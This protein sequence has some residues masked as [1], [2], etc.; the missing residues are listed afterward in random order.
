MTT[1]IEGLPRDARGEPVFRAPWQAQAFAMAVRLHEA[2]HFTWPE[3]AAAL[4]AQIQA[5]QAAGDPDLGDT[6]YEH[7][8]AALEHLVAAKGLVSRDELA[9]RKDAWAE[10]A[11]ATPHGQPI[12]L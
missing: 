11:R 1:E 3:W 12:E 4:A 8:L 9:A 7:W 10:A 5:A 6:Y 2:G